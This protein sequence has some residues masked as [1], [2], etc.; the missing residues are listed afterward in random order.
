MLEAELGESEKKMVLGSVLGEKSG[1]G[2]FILLLAGDD[3]E[4]EVEVD[5][6]AADMVIRG[7]GRGG[8]RGERGGGAEEVEEDDEEGERGDESLL[9][10]QG[11]CGCG[12]GCSCCCGDEGV[13]ESWCCGDVGSESSR[14]S[15]SEEMG[16]SIAEEREV[17][18]EE[19]THDT[20]M[21]REKRTSAVGGSV[22]PVLVWVK[23]IS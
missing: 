1:N 18:E 2:E 4:V 9:S 12:C 17:A 22:P 20:A 23:I 5:E 8:E 11:R 10:N 16:M 19:S 3:V 7:G 13:A 14:P 21:E 6:V 15:S